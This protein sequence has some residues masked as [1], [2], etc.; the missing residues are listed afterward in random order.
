MGLTGPRLL[1]A[2]AVVQPGFLSGSSVSLKA[3]TRAQVVD[4]EVAVGV[5]VAVGVALA[6]DVGV[7]LAEVHD[8][9]V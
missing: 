8:V 4:V 9:S 2:V 1:A 6:D 7:G 3:V 5:G